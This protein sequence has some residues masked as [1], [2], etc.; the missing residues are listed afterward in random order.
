VRYYRLL[1]NR[2]EQ[3]QAAFALGERQDDAN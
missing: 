3:R 1:P 2:R